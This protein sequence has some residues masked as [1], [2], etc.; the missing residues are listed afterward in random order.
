VKGGQEQKKPSLTIGQKHFITLEFFI[1]FFH[2][3]SKIIVG[4]KNFQKYTAVAVVN[5]GKTE[6][7]LWQTS[8]VSP[9]GCR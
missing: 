2:D 7:P 9:A 5:R 8:V 3:F 6:E 4:N 1:F